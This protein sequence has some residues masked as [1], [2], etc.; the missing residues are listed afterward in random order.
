M[1]LMEELHGVILKKL[2]SIC[3]II[4]ISMNKN[5]FIIQS[6]QIDISINIEKE[7]NGEMK[8]H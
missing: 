1:I 8:Q 2:Q 5:P 3:N 7:L 4:F 6:N